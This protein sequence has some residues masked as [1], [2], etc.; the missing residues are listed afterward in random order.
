MDTII[1]SEVMFDENISGELPE[2]IE[3]INNRCKP[4]FESWGYRFEIL[5]AEKTYMDCFNHVIS[6]GPRQGLRA[7]FPMAGSYPIYWHSS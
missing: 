2:H 1:F 4:L 3:F 7:G 5:R 6:R